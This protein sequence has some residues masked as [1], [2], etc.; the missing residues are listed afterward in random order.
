MFGGAN[1]EGR[2]FA[3]SSRMQLVA[4]RFAVHEDGRAFDLATGARV[5]I[6][7]G[8]A[9]GIAEQLRWT[10]RCD[11]LRT[12]RHRAVAPLIDFGLVGEHRRFEAW[13]CGGAWRGDTGAPLK[14]VRAQAEG[15]SVHAIVSRWMRACGLSAGDLSRESLR[16]GAS[17]GGVWVPDAGS[18]YPETVDEE[19]Q[20]GLRIADR[21]MQIIERR[22]VPALAEMFQATDSARPHVSTLWG[23][24]GSGK[25]TAISELARIARVR[26]LVPVAAR[27]IESTHAELWRGRSLFIIADESAERTWVAFLA[28]ALRAAQSHVLLL[29]GEAESRSVAGVSI[30]RLTADALVA[31]IRPGVVGGRFEQAVRRVATRAHGL[32]GRFTRQLWR[33]RGSQHKVSRVVL[34]RVA[35]QA[36]VYGRDESVD[37][38]FAVAPVPCAWP[39]P[40]ELVVLRRRLDG[41]RDA[42]ANGRHASGIRQLRQCIG[43]LARRG[44]WS[45]AAHGATALAQALLRRGRTRDAQAV[46]DD[47]RDYATRADEGIRLVDLATLRGEAWID[48]GRLDEADSVLGTALAAAQ[49]HEDP[50][51]ANAASLALARGSYWRG[52]Y[53]DAHAALA[54]GPAPSA[55][56]VR[57]AV[58]AMRIAAGRGDLPGAMSLLSEVIARAPGYGA[59]ERAHLASVSAFLHLVVGDLNAAEDDVSRAIALAREAHDPMRAVRARLLRVEVER[60]RGR[61]SAAIDQLHRLRRVVATMPPIVRARWDVAMALSAPGAVPRDVIARQVASTGLGALALYVAVGEGVHAVPCARA[62]IDAPVGYGVT[63]APYR[64]DPFADEL[65]AILRVCQTAADETTLLKEICMRLRQHLH[66][67]AVGVVAVRGAHARVIA[68]NG[69]RFDTGVAERAVAAGIPIDAHRRDD[70]IEAAAP[71]EYGGASIGALCARWSVGS[72]YDIARAGSVLAMSAAAV[73]P[74]LAA[75]IARELQTVTASKDLLGITN[76]M[77]E[78]RRSIERAAAAP[79][80]VLIDGE[81]GS[82]K[83]LVARAIH[84]GS[85]RRQ[86]AFC[87]LNCAALPDDLVEAELFGHVRGAFTGAIADR[88][89]VFEDAHGGTLFLD[90]VGELSPRAQAKLLRVIQ[91]GELRRVGEN[92]SRCVDVRI[93]SATNRALQR[94][95]DSGAFRLDLLYRLDVVHITVPPLRERREDITLLADHFWHDAAQRVGS[96]ATLGAAALTALARYD[97]PGN[98]RELQNVLAALA[99]RTPKRGVIPP[100]ALPAP[101]ADRAAG[102]AFTLDEARRT[103]EL[104]FVRAALVRTGG[105]RGRAAAE[106]GVTRQGLTKLMTR[107]GISA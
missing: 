67:A 94:E 61:T 43:G 64:G 107:L 42:L 50:D 33:G 88:A 77:D 69:A 36:A 97:W 103:F 27:L 73:A 89:G 90:E 74:M 105:H 10:E 31:A 56:L 60:R 95:V 20:D 66:A 47:G 26:G 34:P 79:F 98:V 7:L 78:L 93:V 100:T 82:G 44:A 91:D 51:R 48:L 53:A 17:G 46:I 49:A 21:G 71:V 54:S 40:G 65:V 52:R 4:D 75:V 8:S 6:T 106:L 59:G 84:R 101:F 16:V 2:C 62:G 39:A 5:T 58:L 28:A 23:P 32:P 3:Q 29:I 37:D 76:V 83:E 22:A 92:V 81:S 12:L 9:G 18:G 68:S 96:R 102:D 45:D 70:R 13:G 11:G 85:T 24:P 57:R 1:P 41:A 25:M 55:M 104:R 99:V 35:E 38:P 80:A 14:S 19:V 30:G 86:K 87:T 15:T 63:A 72:T